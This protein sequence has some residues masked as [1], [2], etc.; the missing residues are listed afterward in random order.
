MRRPLYKCIYLHS[1]QIYI[2]IYLYYVINIKREYTLV[3]RVKVY[4]SSQPSCSFVPV[5]DILERPSLSTRN[6]I[7]QKTYN[8]KGGRITYLTEYHK[9][10]MSINV[11]RTSL[12]HIASMVEQLYRKGKKKT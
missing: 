1:I 8:I 5:E 7:T 3:G 4:L 9:N 12:P 6:Y 2:L 11:Y 10:V